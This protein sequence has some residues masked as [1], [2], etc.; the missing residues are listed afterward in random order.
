MSNRAPDPQGWF[1][2]FGARER[3]A[4]LATSRPLSAYFPE[5]ARA[6]PMAGLPRPLAVGLALGL[7]AGLVALLAFLAR[8]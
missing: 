3:R 8:L 2:R 6:R 4:W 7:A 1:T 5:T